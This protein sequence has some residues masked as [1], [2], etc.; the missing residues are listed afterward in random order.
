MEPALG[1]L[2]LRLELGDE[3]YFNDGAHNNLRI[4]FGPIFRFSPRLQ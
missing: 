3:I 1:P 4:T 2:G